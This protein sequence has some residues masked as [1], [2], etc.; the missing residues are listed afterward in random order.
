MY[1][2]GHNLIMTMDCPSKC[3]GL[4]LNKLLCYKKQRIFYD[5]HLEGYFRFV[6]LTPRDRIKVKK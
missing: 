5:K 2:E 4:D 6:D 3:Y 1:C